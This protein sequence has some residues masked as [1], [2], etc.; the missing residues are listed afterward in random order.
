M[1]PVVLPQLRLPPQVDQV[2][3]ALHVLRELEPLQALIQTIQVSTTLPMPVQTQR[4]RLTAKA[5]PVVVVVQVVLQPH[6]TVAH[7]SLV[8]ALK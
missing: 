2:V 1:V 3:E 5:Q 8:S 4:A 6:K 7:R